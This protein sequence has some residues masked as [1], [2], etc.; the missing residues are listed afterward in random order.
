MRSSAANVLIEV[1]PSMSQAVD[2]HRRNPN[3][4]QQGHMW[5]IDASDLDLTWVAGK[6]AALARV[7][8]TNLEGSKTQALAANLHSEQEV[9]LSEP[10]WAESA[11]ADM[12]AAAAVSQ[13]VSS[14]GSLIRSLAFIPINPAHEKTVDRLVKNR[15]ARAR[16]R[17]VRDD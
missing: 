7:L 5:T 17:A 10:E 11:T 14:A 4:F 3:W 6:A 8:R 2:A 12:S 16:S 15:I 9:N 1:E 13:L